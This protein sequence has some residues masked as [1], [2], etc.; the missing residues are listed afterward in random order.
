MPTQNL[1]LNTKNRDRAVKEKHIQYGP[2]N[3][4]DGILLPRLLR[5]L[6]VVTALHLTYLL[7]WMNVCHY[8]LI[9]TVV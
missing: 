3:L 4:K 5:N 2:L 6:I 1:K 7:E 8:L 9:K